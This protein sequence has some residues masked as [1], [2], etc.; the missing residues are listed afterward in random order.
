VRKGAREATGDLFAAAEGGGRGGRVALPGDG[1]SV[2]PLI[3]SPLV[4]ETAEWLAGRTPVLGALLSSDRAVEYVAILRAF[5]DFR[6][7][8]EPE[9]LHEDV[10]HAVC[11]EAAKTEDETTFKADLR[12]LKDWGLVT[13]RIE[14]ERLRGYRDNRR[15]KFRYRM[16]DEAAALVDWLAERKSRELNSDGDVT[17]NLLD[18]QCSLL[19]ELRRKLRSVRGGADGVRALPE[20]EGGGHAGRM[21]LPAGTPEDV[22]ADLAGDVLY[23]VGQMRV[24]VEATARALQ[25]L[26]LRLLSFG[27]DSFSIDEAKPVVDELALFLDRFGRRF[28]TLRAEIADDLAELRRACHAKRWE[29]CGAALRAEAEKFRHIASVRIP[30]AAVLLADAA[31]F[32]APDGAL[33]DL[34]HRIVDSARKVWGKLNARLRELERRNHRLED[35]GLR[36]RDLARLGEDE[37]P[38][39]WFR[40]LLRTASLRGDA[41]IRPGG[42]KSVAPRPKASAK[43]VSRKAVTW[44]TP[45]TVGD[46]ANVASIAQVRAE[47]LKAWMRERGIY[48][49]GSATR[50][51]GLTVSGFEDFPNVVRLIG[52]VRL[53]EGEKARRYLNVS[54]RP[55]GSTTTL[56]TSE[57]CLSCEDLELSAVTAGQAC[58]I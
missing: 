6:R 58:R 16:C 51:S 22:S 20:G 10:A 7:R 12:Q 43:A 44:I 21:A 30:D 15:T 1:A 40:G 18:L 35:L 5:A 56:G 27:A 48:P 36:L 24:Y 41:Q 54:A 23:R 9:P 52:Q 42:E 39:G 11:G 32:Y 8:H 38:Y 34:M 4:E 2:V 19:H 57:T 50:L 17:G 31:A 49:D 45:R 28:G 47:R 29:A 3:A 37:V 25:E 46:R 53:G 55:V 14:K 33:V 26:N 13:E